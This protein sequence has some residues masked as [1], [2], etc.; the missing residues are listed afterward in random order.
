MNKKLHKEILDY[1]KL[2]NIDDVDTFIDKM[3]SQGFNVEKYGMTPVGQLKS[4]TIEVEKIVE[5]EKVVEVEVEKIVEII[6]E[7]PVE[8]I[9]E[10]YRTDDEVVNKLQTE[11]SEIKET[12]RYSIQE[13][14]D[15][16]KAFN[17]INDE[18]IKTNK[19]LT[20]EI[21]TLKEKINTNNDNSV[22]LQKIKNLEVELELEKNRNTP[23]K[24]IETIK[25]KKPGLKNIINWVS[26]N[27]R[28]G[29]VWGEE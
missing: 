29:D 15:D 27:E 9:K 10:V 24:K 17:D 3:L 6:K 8:I 26:K 5:V 23:I 28:D 16:R 1:C 14:D 19:S 2:N 22:L 25:E 7:V 4:S 12:L 20:K 21:E 11:L 13:F 18:H